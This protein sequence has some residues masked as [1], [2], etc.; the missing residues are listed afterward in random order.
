MLA[1]NWGPCSYLGVQN[2]TAAPENSIADPQKVKY[3]NY[4]MTQ[5]SYSWVP[6]PKI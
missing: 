1:R 3:R 4:H 6:T 5:Q 2:G